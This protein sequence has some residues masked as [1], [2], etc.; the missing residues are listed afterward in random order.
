MIED[1][2][3]SVKSFSIQYIDDII[4]SNYAEEWEDLTEK[5]LQ[6]IL[7]VFKILEDMQLYADHVSVISL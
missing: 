2:L 6:H 5:H 3:K 1:R 7:E 4:V